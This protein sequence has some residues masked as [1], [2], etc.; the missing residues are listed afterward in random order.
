MKLFSNEYQKPTTHIA[1]QADADYI[2]S[3]AY[4]NDPCSGK[5]HARLHP[6]KRRVY[7]VPE[8]HSAENRLDLPFESMTNLTIAVEISC[9]EA[10][11]HK[12]YR[13]V[14]AENPERTKAIE[15][16]VILMILI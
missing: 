2:L 6:F 1:H 12:P 14:R 7:Y 5:M 3:F 11:E 4:V 10:E 8:N 15:D 16:E 13:T 9:D